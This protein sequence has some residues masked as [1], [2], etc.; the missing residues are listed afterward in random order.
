MGRKGEAAPPRSFEGVAWMDE[1][2]R[3]RRQ[4]CAR[5]K[6]AIDVLLDREDKHARLR[7][8]IWK[9]IARIADDQNP[10]VDEPDPTFLGIPI[11]TAQLPAG[12]DM[13][14]A[15]DRNVVFLMSDGK[16]VEIDS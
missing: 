12:V 2:E 14:I 10:Y 16:L 6:N 11:T 4:T 5:V 15:G 13:A 1:T 8:S 3:V 7:K 9:V